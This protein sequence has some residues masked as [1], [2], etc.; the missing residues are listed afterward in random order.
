MIAAHLMLRIQGRSHRTPSLSHGV[1]A[2]RRQRAAR[3][4]PFIDSY[5]LGPLL[6]QI[7]ISSATNHYFQMDLLASLAQ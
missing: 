6:L 1:C 4:L 3:D 7:D 2:V 5:S